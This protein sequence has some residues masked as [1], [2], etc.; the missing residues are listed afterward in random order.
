M[1]KVE[2]FN[3]QDGKFIGW[4]HYCPGCKMHHMFDKRWKF[5]GD[6]EKPTFSPSMLVRYTWGK[7]QKECRCH[8]YLRNGEI[9]YLSDCL[10]SLKGKTI[11]LEQIK[12]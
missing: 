7:E 1:P 9:R 6:V 5:N 11:E 12:E 2:K 3:D 10:H 4:G 8:Y